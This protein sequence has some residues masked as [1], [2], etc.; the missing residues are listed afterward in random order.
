MSSRQTSGSSNII[1]SFKLLKGNTRISVLFEPLWGIPFV[2]FNFYLS[3]YMK[4]LGVTDR[5]IGYLI[6]IGFIA[7][8]VFSALGGLITD[9]LGRKKTTLIFDFVSWPLTLF[10]Y[11]I[12]N[13]FWLFALTA[14]SNNV[15]RIVQVSWNMMVIEDADN[16]QRLAAFNILNIINLSA[17]VI[18]PV[19][20]IFVNAF[21]VVRSERI[22][23]VFAVLSMT[24]MVLA[25]NHFYSETK[26]G[27]HILDEH[28]KNPVKI[29]LKN[30]FPL[31]AAGAYRKS[32]V[33]VMAI[34]V[35]V[36]FNV[37][38]PLGTFGSLYFAPY[39]TEVLMLGKST[40]SILGGVYSVTMFIVFVFVIPVINRFP[41]T[42]NMLIGLIIQAV[43]LFSL[44]VIPAGSL[45]VTVLCITLFAVG[46]GVFRPFIDSLLAEVTEGRERAGIYSI[47]NTITCIATAVVGFVSGSIY[48][49]NPRLL[50]IVSIIIL[51]ICAGILISSF[52]SA[53][54]ALNV[55]DG[56]V[57][58]G[59]VPDSVENP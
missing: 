35:F 32:P 33:T 30:I 12:S 5:E 10:I 57:P 6:S 8:T 13:N 27:Q 25:R 46:F 52:K 42:L 37:Y 23:L 53:G 47:V 50:Y 9:R 19:A 15:G 36:L 14:I 11:I 54:Y 18:I 4:E 59:N 45:I 55:P 22:F 48:L 56:N 31:K 24:V 29:S 3:L 26:T 58:D 2:L 44:I 34:C 39:M 21:G 41:K 40:I 38:L 43:S 49:F 7:G 28:R 20:G 51:L 1:G 17:G 16:E